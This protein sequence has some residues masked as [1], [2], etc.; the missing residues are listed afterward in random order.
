MDSIPSRTPWASGP[1]EILQ[2]A[3]ELSRRN[4]DASRRLALLTTDNAVELMIKAY[5]GLP[6]R[7]TGINLPKKEY[8]EISDSFPR[9]LEAL[10]RVAHAKTDAFDL[11]AVEWF[12]RLRNELYHNGNGLTVP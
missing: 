1:A 11:G 2:H 5:L 12:H 8:D 10:E 9:L 6:K 3:F 7:V 4:T